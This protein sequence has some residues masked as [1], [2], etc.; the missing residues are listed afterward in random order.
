MCRPM[1]KMT[2]SDAIDAL[3]TRIEPSYRKKCATL[4]WALLLRAWYRCCMMNA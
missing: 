2:R 1:P 3:L 4:L